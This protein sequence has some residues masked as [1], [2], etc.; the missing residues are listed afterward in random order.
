MKFKTL[1]ST[2]FAISLLAFVACSDDIE[3]IGE[4]IQP[5]GDGVGLSVDSF[6]VTAETASFDNK[7]YARTVYGT[8]GKYDDKI[9][10]SVKSDFLCEFYVSSDFKF[11]KHLVAID[12]V[13]VSV[14]FDGT[15][16]GY[17]G[18]STAVMGIAAY[19]LDKDLSK[20]YYTNTDPSSYYDK[21]KPALGSKAYSIK[22]I[23]MVNKVRAISLDLD[24]VAVGRRIYN[25]WLADSTVFNSATSFKKV[26]KGMYIANTYGS[27]SLINVEQTY[28]NIYYKYIGRNKAN[29][30]DSIRTTVISFPVTP[31]VVQLNHVENSA[32]GINKLINPS[33]K[34]KAYVKSPA[35][36]YTKIHIPIGEIAQKKNQGFSMLNSAS[37]ALKGFTEEEANMGLSSPTY[38]LCVPEDSLATYF[39][40]NKTPGVDPTSF[41]VSRTST[42]NTYSFGNIS[43]HIQY[44]IN[45][46]SADNTTIP[47]NALLTYCLIPVEVEISSTTATYTRVVNTMKPTGAVFRTDA[48]NMQISIIQSKFD[49]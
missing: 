30:G 16:K 38:L 7:V 39:V 21:T 8:L 17:I 9:L 26:I 22:G 18:D 36:V 1:L 37:F 23:P 11:Q 48:K 13:S 5:G 31:D 19:E 20:V 12:S 33:I 47:T 4:S 15:K 46:M 6:T 35:G 42:S 40:R 3:T 25:A 10:G 34:D 43:T 49:K 44:Y 28:L 45:K 24:T 14:L 27:G 2:L 32:A 29:S 41:I